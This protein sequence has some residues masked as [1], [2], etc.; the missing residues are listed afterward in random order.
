MGRITVRRRGWDRAAYGWIRAR[1]AH[2]QHGPA[3]HCGLRQRRSAD[4]RAPARSTATTIRRLPEWVYVDE[5]KRAGYVLAAVTVT[6]P[7]A[8]R[9]AVREL[10]VPGRRSLHMH[11][12][13]ARRWRLIVSTLV[14]LP[15]RATIYDAARRYRNR[16]GSSRRL[17]ERPRV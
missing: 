7:D 13:H 14:Q 17:P 9:R 8:A 11:N 2:D 3:R 16:A 15:I 10:L 12:E 6:D 5:T 4:P 1:C